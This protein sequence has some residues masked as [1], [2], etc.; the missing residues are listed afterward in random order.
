MTHSGRIHHGNPKF[1]SVDRPTPMFVLG[2]DQVLHPEVLDPETC[3]EQTLETALG[4]R[5]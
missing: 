4:G 2:P 3:G 5:I 1:I